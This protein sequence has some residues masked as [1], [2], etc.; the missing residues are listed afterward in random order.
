[1]SSL[2]ERVAIPRLRVHGTGA[3]QTDAAVVE[4]RAP[5]PPRPPARSCLLFAPAPARVHTQPTLPS[6]PF[7]HTG[8]GH[9]RRHHADAAV[10]RSHLAAGDHQ[11]W[12]VGW[13]GVW[14][15]WSCV[16]GVRAPAAGVA[17]GRPVL[18][19]LLTPSPPSLPHTPSG[20]IGH[21]AHGKST[22]VKAISGVQTVRFKNE[23]ERNITIKLGYANAK[24]YKAADP[25]VPRPWCYKAYGSSKEDAPP[26]DVPGFEGTKMELLRHVS[27]VDCP[28]ECLVW[29]GVG[30]RR[31]PHSTT[32]MEL[33]LLVRERGRVAARCPCPPPIKNT[34]HPHPSFPP[35][36]PSIRP[37]HPHGHHA[38][39]GRRHGWRPAADCRQ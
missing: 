5:S 27:F 22:V 12:Y 38:Q 28:G 19:S 10:A 16:G 6:P 18:I 25:A 34:P 35:T 7:H 36:H 24:I 26:C 20:T 31:T 17:R 14:L 33:P 21:V 13:W 32:S 30:W 8:P 15:V 3:K 1:M 4:R 37:R 39:R 2:R 29:G 23:L 9:A 11:H